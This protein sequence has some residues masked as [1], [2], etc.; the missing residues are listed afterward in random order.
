MPP[1]PLQGHDEH[2]GDQEI[3]A[4]LEA[5]LPVLVAVSCHGI[6]LS[7]CCCRLSAVC[8]SH[9]RTLKGPQ[10][11]CTESPH[12]P[13]FLC[14]TCVCLLHCNLQLSACSY[15]PVHV[16]EGVAH[17]DHVVETSS[18]ANVKPPEVRFKHN[19]QVS[20]VCNAVVHNS[21]RCR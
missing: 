14:C 8:A 13:L 5:A 16:L 19:L 6:A 11:C 1:V 10:V 17:P 9:W 12:G 18:L 20:Y 4:R 3:Y 2:T 21:Y 15:Q 7:L